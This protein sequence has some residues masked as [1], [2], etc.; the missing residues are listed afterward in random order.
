MSRDVTTGRFVSTHGGRHEK[1]Y[2]IWCAMK[3]RC[4][5]PHNKRF[6]RYGGRGIT[7][8]IWHVHLPLLKYNKY[9]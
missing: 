2:N 9:I 7:F 1:L 5:N 3:E 8:I 6:S 4:N